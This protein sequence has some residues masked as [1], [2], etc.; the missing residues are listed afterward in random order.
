M[1]LIDG[2]KGQLSA[3]H[4][5]L[6]KLGLADIPV[7]GLAKEFEEIYRPGEKEP[8]RVRALKRRMQTKDED[9]R[10]GPAE[11]ILVIQ[12]LGEDS[13]TDYAVS[14]ARQLASLLD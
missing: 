3:A 9:G 10:V 6:K 8:L 14:N 1:I 2:G 7:I 12:K 5:E 11:T 13:R 4:G